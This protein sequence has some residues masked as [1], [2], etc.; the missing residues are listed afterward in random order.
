MSFGQHQDTE[1]WNPQRSNECACLSHA[2]EWVAISIEKSKR[3][4][5]SRFK[6]RGICFHF[7]GIRRNKTAK[8]FTL[9]AALKGASLLYVFFD[10]ETISTTMVNFLLELTRS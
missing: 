3:Q 2:R 9:N 8:V 10:K 7:A 5:G 6:F 1:L 4:N